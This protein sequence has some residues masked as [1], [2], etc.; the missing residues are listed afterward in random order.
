[1]NTLVADLLNVEEALYKFN[2]SDL[3]EAA[4][5]LYQVLYYPVAPSQVA[6]NDKVKEFIFV[7]LDIPVQFSKEE[8]SILET[9]KSVSILFNLESKNRGREG[10]GLKKITFIAIDLKCTMKD[11]SF[12]A[13]SITQIIGKGFHNAIFYL[14]RNNDSIMFSGLLNVKGTK[15]CNDPRCQDTNSKI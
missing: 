3:Y 6:I 5:N 14:F 1:M 15:K 12:I 2:T 4:I 11:R 8:L 10:N 13:Y 7:K 9:V